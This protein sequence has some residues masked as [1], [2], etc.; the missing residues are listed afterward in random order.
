MGVSHPT[1]KPQWLTFAGEEW[2]LLLN[3]F[4]SSASIFQKFPKPDMCFQLNLLN[5]LLKKKPEEKKCFFPPTKNNLNEAFNF[6]SYSTLTQK[7][8]EVNVTHSAH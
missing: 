4:I 2:Q 8:H 6:T 7:N 5:L 3:N 1:V